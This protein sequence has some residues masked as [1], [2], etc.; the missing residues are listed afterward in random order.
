MGNWLKIR[1]ANK[2]INPIL[3]QADSTQL[4]LKQVLDKNGISKIQNARIV[5]LDHIQYY[6]VKRN[7]NLSYYNSYSGTLLQEGDIN[8]ARQIARHFLGDATANIK[9]VSKIEHYTTDYKVINRLLPVYK[10][11]FERDDKMSVYVHTGS[12]KLG[13]MNNGVKRFCLWFFSTF[14]NWDF[15]GENVVFKTTV[16]FLFS[17]IIFV[18]GVIGLWI[19]FVNRDKYKSRKKG[20]KKLKPRNRHR[21]LSVVTSL[22]LLAFAFSGAFH[23]FKKYDGVLLNELEPKSTIQSGDIQITIKDIIHQHGPVKELSLTHFDN[24]TY[25]R[26]SDTSLHGAPMYYNTKT[27]QLLENGN[28]AYALHR[29][30]AISGLDEKQITSIALIT[31]FGKGYGFI[32]KRLPVIKV[33]FNDDNHTTCY[34][35]T[36]SGIPGAIMKKSDQLESFSFSYLHK[37]HMLNFMGKGYRDLIMSLASLIVLLIAMTGLVIY[38]KM[39]VK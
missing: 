32:N 7:G 24:H 16:V 4:S 20:I 35:E 33:S 18:T 5:E 6:Q 38:I 23:A 9:T 21:K 12:S 2:M 37:Y 31:R 22:L 30:L 26:V 8:Y 13:T 19:Y 14:H 29:A 1:P 28:E 11:D 39:K 27:S 36:S 15:L 3:I 10:V 34:I 17:V 25:Y